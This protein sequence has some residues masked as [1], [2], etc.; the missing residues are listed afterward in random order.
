MRANRQ[1]SARGADAR[2]NEDAAN[3]T[4]RVLRAN[5]LAPY[6]KKCCTPKRSEACE[7][8]DEGASDGRA[9]VVKLPVFEK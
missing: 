9:A 4:A 5:V 8:V 3:G 2:R 1:S 6:Q 7:L